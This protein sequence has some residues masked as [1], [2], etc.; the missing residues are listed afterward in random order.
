MRAVGVAQRQIMWVILISIALTVALVARGVVMATPAPGAELWMM[1]AVIVVVRVGMI[2][3]MMVGVYRLT[4]ALHM[5]MTARVLYMLAMLVP[6]LGIILLLIV[7]QKATKLLNAHGIKV[8]LMGAKLVH[9][10]AA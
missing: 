4:T 3:L 2:V 9:L 7:N 6:Y 1:L 8:G 5:G 10:P